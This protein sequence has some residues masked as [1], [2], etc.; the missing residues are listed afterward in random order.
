MDL[1]L[2]KL[3][4]IVK[5]MEVWG[6]RFLEGT[7]RNVC[8]PGP[9][10]KEKW[11][12]KRLTQTCLWVSR[13]LWQRHGSVAA[14]CRVGG[15]ECSSA[16]IGPFEGGPI[17]LITSTIFD[18]RSNSREGTCPTLEQK[19]GL[20]IYWTWPRPSEQDPDSPSVSLFHEE[21]SIS[22]LS[23]SIRGQTDWKLPTPITFTTRCCFCIGSISSLHSFWS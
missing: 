12:Q 22:L 7:N 6:N 21:A 23:F 2:G 17:I 1:S 5:D 18:F 20:K 19:I 15:T 10:R 16:C 14:W 11:P 8:V 13:S 3:Q 9:R 4:E